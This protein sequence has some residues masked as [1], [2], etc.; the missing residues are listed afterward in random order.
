MSLVLTQVSQLF[1][2]ARRSETAGL[3]YNS[4][5]ISISLLTELT[6]K[7]NKTYLTFK[8]FL[9]SQKR[10]DYK[11]ALYPHSALALT[12]LPESS[13]S[14]TARAI[15]SQQSGCPLNTP[16]HFSLL[17]PKCSCSQK[18]LTADARGTITPYT[19]NRI[20]SWLRKQLRRGAMPMSVWRR[21]A[22]LA[23]P[24]S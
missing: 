21:D 11:Q 20:Q 9:K 7:L 4:A 19:F 10:S 15:D 3:G 2:E 1:V 24:K 22:V 13:Q 16:I 12:S 6:K 8:S 18:A 23:S 14:A 17:P 5:H